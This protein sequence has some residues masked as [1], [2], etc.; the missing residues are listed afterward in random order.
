MALNFPASPALNDIHTD[1]DYKFK[2]DGNKWVSI[3]PE[4]NFD[5]ITTATGN[6]KIVVSDAD[7]SLNIT[8]NSSPAIT[9]D[10]SQQVGIGTSSPSAKL[11]LEL[12]TLTNNTS[13]NIIQLGDGGVGGAGVSL[14]RYQNAQNYGLSFFTTNGT[15]VEKMRITNAGNVGIG[16]TS[17]AQALDIAS[18]APNIRFTDTVDGHSEIDGN[19][20]SLKFNADKGNQKADSTITFFVDNTERLRILSGGGLTFNGDTADA[21]ALDDYEEGTWTP[22]YQGATSAGTY[23]YGSRFGNYTKIGNQVHVHCN[24]NNITV[25]TAGTGIAQISGLPFTAKAN[26]GTYQGSIRL[27]RFNVVDDAVTIAVSLNGNSST[28]S[29]VET[30]DAQ[31]AAS[32]AVTDRMDGN[33]DV[34]FNITYFVA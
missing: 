28:A 25:T 24:I 29:L 17:P 20:A 19:A 30:R 1:G 16:T 8:T 33:S 4:G 2:W 18:T 15:A 26:S 21:N 22:V 9:V 14:D 31:S 6:N 7:N 13:Q 34:Y 23:A 5:E 3:G 27:S 32:V 12:T 11:D 10:S